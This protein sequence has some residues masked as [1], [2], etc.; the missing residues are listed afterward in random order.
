MLV[1]CP[2]PGHLGEPSGG[3]G[4]QHPLHQVFGN[5]ST[6]GEPYRIHALQPD[7][8]QLARIVDPVGPLLALTDPTTIMQSA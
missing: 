6:R 5:R 8:I 4:L 1:D 3:Q 2:G 7:G